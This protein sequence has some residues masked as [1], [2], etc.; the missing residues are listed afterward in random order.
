[1][2]TPLE[3]EETGKPKRVSLRPLGR[4]KPYLLRHKGMLLAALVS[5]VVAAGAMLALP[6]ALRRMIDLGFSGIEPELVDV[7]FGTLVGVGALLAIA[8]AARFYCVNWLGERVVADIR[9][10]VFKH[11]TGL[12]PAFY[13][14]SH[15]GEVMS[16]LTADTTQVK[17]AAGT[18]VSQAMR[19][20]L[21]VVGSVVM[22]IVTSPKL[23]LAVL[24]AIPLIVLPL[25][26]Y[27]R[28]VRARSRY[29]QDTLAE[30]SAYASESL[31]Q[32]KVLQAFTNERAA[33]SRFRRAMDRAFEAA[34]DRAKARAG[35]TAIAMF[36]VFLS[37]VGVLWYG[38]QDVLSGSMTGGTLGQ[39]VLYAVFAAAAVGG[40]SDVWGEVAQ[41]AGAAE[42]LGELLEAE[43]EI[44]SPPHPTPMPEPGRGE[45]AFDDVS[46][47]YPLRPD[48]AAL[49]SVSF[50]VKPGERVA[51]VGPSGAGKTTIFA[52][53]LRFYDPKSGTVRLDDV[54]VDMA[55]LNALRSR[56][57]MVPQETA[58]FADT[59]AANIAYGADTATRAQV[60]AAA[61]AAFAHDFITE[62]PEGYETQLG[63]GGV[64]LSGGQR[65][66][67]AIARAVLRDAPILLLDEA[68]SALDT[69][70]ETLVQKALDKVMDGRTTLVIAH[71]LSTVVNADR[72]L[73]FDRG[74]LVE[75]GTHQQLIAKSGLYARL[76]SLQFAP[77]AA[78]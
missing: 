55:D 76:A 2:E 64:T 57:A 44:Q 31:G 3:P 47:T 69:T 10:D 54:P 51:L 40:L 39:F 15:S 60:E 16:R 67:I 9:T 50:T 70:N 74:A 24:I 25:V 43:S 12:S 73:V 27:G 66:R 20:L 45:I 77:D 42:R 68:T 75:E 52:L 4:L 53:L 17:A 46:F 34:N 37:V 62:L 19:N 22:M 65:Q 14:V 28:S 59:V 36:L 23:S 18:A 7:Y 49:D 71:R 72:I 58:L 26:A 61:K 11:L 41:A 56:F 5:L 32:V 35:L 6:L 33:T 38:A 1:M 48:I 30:A 63:E 29:A 78:E 8:S 13:E 21:L